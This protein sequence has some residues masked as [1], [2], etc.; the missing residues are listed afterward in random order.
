[1][2]PF[3]L[4]AGLSLADAFRA[5]MEG[6]T[7]LPGFLEKFERDRSDGMIL[8][9]ASRRALDALEAKSQPAAD[10]RKG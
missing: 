10:P 8:E 3:H 2:H 6:S 7:E 1:M 5:A 4:N 9:D